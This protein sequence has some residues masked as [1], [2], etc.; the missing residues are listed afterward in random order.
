MEKSLFRKGV[1]DQVKHNASVVRSR[2]APE[3]TG[4]TLE[5]I[6][7]KLSNSTDRDRIE[8]LDDA[9]KILDHFI[10]FNRFCPLRSLP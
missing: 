10:D 9:E 1:E 7:Q 2:F 3:V 6:Y 5:N 8:P 4:K